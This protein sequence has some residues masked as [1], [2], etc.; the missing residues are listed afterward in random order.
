LVAGGF[1]A[2]PGE[3]G[4]WVMRALLGVGLSNAFKPAVFW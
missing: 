4:F 3:Q 2:H 1:V